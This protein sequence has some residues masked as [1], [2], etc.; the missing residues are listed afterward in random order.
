MAFS[1]FCFPSMFLWMKSVNLNFTSC[2]GGIYSVSPKISAAFWIKGPVTYPFIPVN[3]NSSFRSLLNLLRGDEDSLHRISWNRLK[4]SILFELRTS[5]IYPGQTDI[6]ELFGGKII[7]MSGNLIDKITRKC[8]VRKS[9]A[10]FGR[11]S[12]L[13]MTRKNSV[14]RKFHQISV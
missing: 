9:A 6:V 10:M 13:H 12:G 7:S 14:P 8:I 1:S 4:Q 2:R 11:K 3:K 5:I